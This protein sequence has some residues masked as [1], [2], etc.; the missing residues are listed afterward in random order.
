MPVDYP[1]SVR[2][3]GHISGGYS[4]GLCEKKRL[5]EHVPNCYRDIAVSIATPNSVKFLCVGFDEEWIY[6]RKTHEMEFLSRIL[7]AADLIN[8]REYQL[9][10]TTHDHRRQVAKYSESD[11][12]ILNF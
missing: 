6:K 4:I 1:G 12:G 5:H 3:K 8:K 9:R 7:D 10:R 11:G 2:R